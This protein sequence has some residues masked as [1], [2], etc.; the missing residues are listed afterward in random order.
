MRVAL[1]AVDYLE[2][3][4]ECLDGAAGTALARR[5]GTEVRRLR[6]RFP[7]LQAQAAAARRANRIRELEVRAWPCRCGEAL[8]LRDGREPG[9]LFWGCSTYPRCTWTHP[10][11]DQ[12]HRFLETGEGG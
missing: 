2:A 12:Q 11:T 3:L 9:A 4:T 1:E 7:G 8:T 10:L 5:I 6:E